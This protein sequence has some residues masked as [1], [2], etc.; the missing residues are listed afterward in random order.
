M[1]HPYDIQ[2]AQ[3]A[4]DDLRRLRR[5]DSQQILDEIERQLTHQ[6]TSSAEAGSS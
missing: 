1:T 6:P 5:F 4:V 2:Y 3:T